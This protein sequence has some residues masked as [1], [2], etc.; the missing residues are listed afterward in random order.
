MAAL[1]LGSSGFIGSNLLT[2]RAWDYTAN[3]ATADCLPT[4]R[5]DL[6]VCCA[7]PGTKWRVNQD[8]RADMLNILDLT[9]TLKRVRTERFLLISTA[10]VFGQPVDADEDDIP[11]P[12]C[13]YGRNR[14]WLENYVRG[15][16]ATATVIRLPGVIGSGLKK[17]A[18]YDLQHGQRLDQLNPDSV[19]Q[20]YDIRNLWEDIEGVRVHTRH[21]CPKPESLAV[22]VARDFPHLA[23]KLTGTAPPA[24]Y[25][26]R[27]KYGQDS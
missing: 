16:Y 4:R 5:Y 2:Q 18:Y 13:A 3:R 12:D 8:P 27:S 11:D 24:R 23:G 20:W 15:L 10:D 1:L 17:N 21:L 9:A 14:L 6:V 25:N 22:T 7:A 19:Y 26:L